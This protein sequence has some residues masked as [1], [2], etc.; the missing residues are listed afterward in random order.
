LTTLSQLARFSTSSIPPVLFI[1]A[2]RQVGAKGSKENIG[3]CS[4]L[5]IIEKINRLQSPIA[6]NYTSDKQKYE[7]INNLLKEVVRNQSA[8]IEIPHELDTINVELDGKLLPL[9]SLGTGIHE[10]IIIAAYAAIEENKIICIEEPEIHLHPELQRQLIQYLVGNTNNQYFIATHSTHMLD[11]SDSAIFHIKDIHGRSEVNAA[12]NDID[13][14]ALCDDIGYRAS[15]ILQANSIIWVEGPSDRIYLN[16]WLT[17]VDPTLIEGVHYSVM[18]YGGRLLAHLSAS[19]DPDED[20]I[21]H[22]IDLGKL[23][24]N[25]SIIIDSDK[26]NDTDDI[27]ETKERLRDEIV[28]R[29]GVAWITAGRTVENYIKHHSLKKTI[30]EKYK[31]N[32]DE[33]ELNTGDFA[34]VTKYRIKGTQKEINKVSIA[35]LITAHD[36]SLDILDLKLQTE[37]LVKF[38]WKANGKVDDEAEQTTKDVQPPNTAP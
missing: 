5:G 21:K 18:F 36:V 13:R 22:F 14:K 34:N 4:G 9:T 1:P 27:N 6:R 12:I 38:I 10:L 2:I 32:D 16:K 29:G 35:C 37:E 28:K 11:V 26:E 15:D 31:I 3:D 19:F 17:K 23:N 8:R 30:C 20:A 33:I 24:Q 7:T 25:M